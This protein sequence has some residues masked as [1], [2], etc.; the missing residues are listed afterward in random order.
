M[1]DLSPVALPELPRKN[2]FLAS[3]PTLNVLDEELKFIRQA[4]VR[5]IVGVSVFGLLLLLLVL[6]LAEVSLMRAPKVLPGMAVNQVKVRADI[7]DRNGEL[8]ATSL[9]TYSLYAEPRKIWDPVA[10]TE[11]IILAL[12]D[13]DPAATGSRFLPRPPA[14]PR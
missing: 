1:K 5:I 10:S 9:N 14:I 7:V 4:R 6:R 13:L 11:A 12:P 2:T 3:A 8:L